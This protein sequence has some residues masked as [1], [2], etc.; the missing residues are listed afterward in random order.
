MGLH[1]IVQPVAK[2]TVRLVPAHLALALPTVRLVDVQTVECKFF[3]DFVTF[4]RVRCGFFRM[5]NISCDRDLK[6]I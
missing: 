5:T 3:R 1:A 6:D 2:H 4:Y